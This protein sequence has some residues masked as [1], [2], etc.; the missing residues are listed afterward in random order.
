MGYLQS[1]TPTRRRSAGR[2]LQALPCPDHA[3]CPAVRAGFTLEAF[4]L[5]IK[6][7][8]QTA[9]G[10]HRLLL[11]ILPPTDRTPWGV[12]PIL[13][14][15]DGQVLPPMPFGQDA[16]KGAHSISVAALSHVSAPARRCEKP[17]WA[18]A[19]PR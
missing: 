2:T 4:G 3:H 11:L 9:R 8:G 18:E 13:P 1:A 12:L 6:H 14:I 5:G 16:K 10:A 19:E 15:V 17:A 7:F